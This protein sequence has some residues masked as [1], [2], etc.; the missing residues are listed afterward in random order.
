[1]RDG[2]L[3]GAILY[4][5]RVAVAMYQDMALTFEPCEYWYVIAQLKVRANGWLQNA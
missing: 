1:M 5:N 4:A 2:R 3:R